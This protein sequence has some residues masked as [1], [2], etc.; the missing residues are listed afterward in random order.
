MQVAPQD[1]DS[2]GEDAL[3]LALHGP[4][5]TLPAVPLKNRSMLRRKRE[6]I[7]EEKKDSVY[8]ERRRRNN[9]AA[10]RSREKRRFNDLVLEN[11]LMA[12][13]EENASLRAE[14]LALKIKFGLVSSS[15]HQEVRSGQRF[16]K[17][18]L[19]Q[20]DLPN[21]SVMELSPLVPEMWAAKR[22]L[23]FRTED[24]KQEAE[25]SSAASEQVRTGPVLV[26]LQP[27]GS[28]SNS[29]RTWEEN[30]VSEDEQR[31]PKGPASS[32]ADQRSVIVSAHKVPEPGSSAL[33]HKLRI[34]S[35]TIQIKAEPPDPEYEAAPPVRC[36]LSLQVSNMLGCAHSAQWL[37]Q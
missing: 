6:F 24:L 27:A 14:L 13:G 17:A 10:K 22:A 23:L 7:P 9:E 5:R 25:E 26:R 35:R 34:K 36:P 18:D 16:M 3:V 19:E 33:P 28:S 8:W 12:L 32:A 11:Q 30:A 15:A 21:T 31:V 2:S 4:N 37:N 1:T 29:P 20:V